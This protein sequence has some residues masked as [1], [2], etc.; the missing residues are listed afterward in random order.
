[1]STAYIEPYDDYRALPKDTRTIVTRSVCLFAKYDIEPVISQLPRLERMKI[2]IIDHDRHA[3]KKII[4]NNP[5]I[6]FEIEYH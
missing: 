1:M 2:T 5:H 3:M 4:K 6:V